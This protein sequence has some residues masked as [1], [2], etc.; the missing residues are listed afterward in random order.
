MLQSICFGA[1]VSYPRHAQIHRTCFRI[2]KTEREHNKHVKTK[3]HTSTTALSAISTPILCYNVH[4]TD[5]FADLL[6]SKNVITD[7][8]KCLTYTCTPETDAFIVVFVCETFRGQRTT[9][10]RVIPADHYPS[11]ALTSE[12]GQT[13]DLD[14]M[15]LR[16]R[17]D[18][19]G[20]HYVFARREKENWCLYNSLG[21]T[22]TEMHTQAEMS[23][24]CFETYVPRLCLYKKSTVHKHA[25]ETLISSHQPHKKSAVHEHAP[26]TP[27][28]LH[29]RHEKR[30][31]T[32]RISTTP[33]FILSQRQMLLRRRA[34]RMQT[35]R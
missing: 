11:N 3:L 28:L 2:C 33:S 13:C 32:P 14:C 35:R 25:P 22:T 21:R 26:K 6:K 15:C 17:T 18:G 19:S 24:V 8:Q 9:V 12:D 1:L 29:Q 34:L 30:T 16:T 10:T 7:R 20:G 23:R 27:S 4:D 31:S 5:A